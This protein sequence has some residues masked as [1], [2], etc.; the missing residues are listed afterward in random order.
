MGNVCLLN[1][2]PVLL[3]KGMSS[4]WLCPLDGS[5]AGD[6]RLLIADPVAMPA[7]PWMT[8][9]VGEV[10]AGGAGSIRW[11]GGGTGGAGAV[12]WMSAVG[13][14]AW[15]GLAGGVVFRLAF[16]GAGDN[17]NSASSRFWFSGCSDVGLG[18]SLSSTSTI[19]PCSSSEPSRYGRMVLRFLWTAVIGLVVFGSCR[20][21]KQFAV[22][23]AL[24]A[25]QFIGDPFDVSCLA[26]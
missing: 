10:G 8:L 15:A 4:G 11:G 9:I 24:D 2:G 25:Q 26:P 12:I 19:S 13:C 18:S 23:N 20:G 17:A 21:D 22:F 14:I 3:P 6:D 7:L 5:P 16:T 1:L